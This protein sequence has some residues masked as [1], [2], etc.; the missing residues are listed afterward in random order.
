[1]KRKLSIILII[2]LLFT[3]LFSVPR[4]ANAATMYQKV[5]QYALNLGVIHIWGAVDKNGGIVW[6]YG[7]EKGGEKE[8][9]VTITMP[10][11]VSDVDAYQLTSSN[12]KW[13][14][15]N[16]DFNG[17]EYLYDKQSYD[18]FYKPYAS[19]N[20][21][22]IH[23]SSSGSKVSLSYTA[24]LKS[25]T[26]FDLAEAIRE[27]NVD[28]VYKLLGGAETLKKANYEL[29]QRLDEGTENGVGSGVYGYM[30]FVPIV[31]QYDVIEK[32]EIPEND[33]EPYLD[34]PEI[35]LTGETY[36]VIDQTEF[37][38]KDQF[39][40]S[41]LRYKAE[42]KESGD[43]IDSGDVEGWD[44]TKLGGSITQAFDEP[45]IVTYTITVWNIYGTSKS[46]AKTIKILAPQEEEPEITVDADLTL[47]EYTYEGHTE[48]ARDQS[49]YVVNGVA[50]SAKR[51]YAEDIASNRFKADDT[52]ID[53]D[54]LTDTKAECTFSKKGTYS[55]TLNVK[56]KTRVK[57]S[58]TESI[59][60]RKTPCI[61]DNLSGFQKQNRK[62]ILNAVVAT[63]PGKPI[64]DYTITL[65]DKVTGD[66]IRLTPDNLQ[67]N[68][69][70][71]KTRAVTMT[72][73]EEK[74]F[75]YL[76]LEFLTKTPAYN[77]A[78]PDYTQDF[79]YEIHVKDSKGDT[80][81]ASSTFPVKPDIP[82]TAAISLDSAFLR[83]EG[84]NTAAIKA[85]DVTVASD[86]D[87]VERTWYYAPSTT[88]S[89]FTNVT[90]MNGYQ[91]LSFGTDKIVGFNKTGVGKFTM[92]LHVKEVWTEPTLEEYVTDAEHLTDITTA[93]SDVQNVAPIVSLDLLRSTE[94]EILL[95]ANNNT[96]YQTLM[97][98]KTE[99]QQALLANCID[100]QI[101]IKKLVGSTPST[102]TKPSLQHSK[103]YPYGFHNPS[104]SNILAVDSEKTYLLTYAWTGVG[105]SSKH[106][107][108]KTIHAI[109]PYSGEAWSYTT[110]RE[111]HF[112]FGQDDTGKYLYLIYEDSNQTVFIDKRTGA[113]AGTINIALSN[114][115]WLSDNLAFITQ[116]HNIYAIN[117][118]SL[119]KTL[120]V[121]NAYAVSRV[122][123]N[124]QYIISTNNAIVRCTL[125][126]ETRSIEKNI[127]IESDSI[128]DYTPICIDSAG[129]AVL[130][131]EK[132]N[133]SDTFEGVVA[134]TADNNLSI[135]VSAG[136][137]YEDRSFI[138]HA[139]DEQGECNHVM[140]GSKDSYKK[141]DKCEFVGV[142]LKT[143]NTESY[144]KRTDNYGYMFGGA[145]GAFESNGTSYFLFSGDD[146]YYN[147]GTSHTWTGAYC[148][149]FTGSSCSLGFY[150]PG[151]GLMDE[152]IK[153][154]DRL[155]AS[156]DGEN[157]PEDGKLH[158]RILAFP[159]TLAQETKEVISRYTNKLTFVGDVNTTAS[160]IIA[161]TELPKSVMKITAANNGSLSLHN[162][163]L[164]QSK[165]YSYEYEIKPL[166][167]GTESKLNGMTA[168]TGT[169]TSSQNFISD[170][171]Y[172][173]DS[174][175]ENFN[176]EKI[177]NDFFTVEDNGAFSNGGYGSDEDIDSHMK[178]SFVVPDGKQAIVSFDYDF[179]F[180][181]GIYEDTNIFIDG[182]RVD[183]SP[184]AS[185]TYGDWELITTGHRMFYKILY[186]GV[187]TIETKKAYKGSWNHVL[188]DNLKVDILSTVPKTINPTINIEEGESEGW[189]H[190]SGT[191]KTLPKTISYGAQSSTYHSGNIASKVT[192]T[193]K[194]YS[195]GQQVTRPKEIEYYQTVP[196]GCYQR[197]FAYTSSDHYKSRR[198]T[199]IID[200]KRYELQHEDSDLTVF[201]PPKTAGTY[202]HSVKISKPKSDSAIISR[203]DLLTYPVNEVTATGNMAFNHSNTKYFFPKVTSNEKTNLSIYLPKGE[204]LIKNLRLYY[205]ENGQKIYMKN[206]DLDE[207]A[208]LSDWTLSTG[209][210]ASMMTVKE[211]KT[212][213]EYVKVYKKGE[214]VLYN[215]FYSD[216]EKDPSKIGYW[217]YTHINWPPDTVHP[218]VGKVL[219][220]PIDRFYLA[221]KYT[222]THWEVDNTQRPG[223][224]GDASS[225]DRESNKE[226]MTFYV[227]G[228][229][230]APWITY[231]KTNPSK[232]KE[233]NSY[234]LNVGVDD[235][236]KDTLTL[237]TEVYLNGKSV[238]TDIK[239]GIQADANGDY[240]E[241]TITGLPT[242]KIGVYQVVC[243]VSD[244]SGTGIKTYKF[245]VVSEGK[246]T[247]FVNHTDQ[248]DINRKKYNLKRFDDEVNRSMLLRDYL[249]LKT[250]RKRG[251]NVFWS[252]EKFMLQSETEGNPTKVTVR[253]LTEDSKGDNINTDYSTQLTNTGSKTALG[254]EIWKGNLWENS[255]INKWG[256]KTPEALNFQFVA[257][258][259]GGLTKTHTVSVI[260]DSERDYWQLHR[261]W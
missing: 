36:T 28:Y 175:E 160:E 87:E 92:K 124:L 229:G 34:V 1:M 173:V 219:T 210:T 49:T 51:A 81:T 157:D 197:G 121:E 203:F 191:F 59:E 100:G 120:V 258:Y 110:S 108:P 248:W 145:S 16:Y 11:E 79:Y 127:L 208:D 23:V 96:E 109:N 129:K 224:V 29:W 217:V 26:D 164:E 151:I 195:H 5:T 111:E 61:V 134:Y 249:A 41:Q 43:V 180:A 227:N 233:N 141:G 169:T 45:C 53:I 206:N 55:V 140:L 179:D 35:A 39:A 189:N 220:S 242:A 148:F 188:I 22:G 102:V 118:S 65:K 115:V 113:A 226:T 122:N 214:K 183:E 204:Y 190:I 154:S 78:V 14:E 131:K 86:G 132:G 68:H 237:E 38:K 167:D 143:G 207:V 18:H 168:T 63:Y 42:G 6:Q 138:N 12:F 247:G 163:E 25:N 90:S 181:A 74:G 82:P 176:S 252:G 95:L 64:T 150:G 149:T 17:T 193:E 251:T 130:F 200:G 60:V 185:P 47:P 238:K 156:I 62:Q 56:T 253:I 201:L 84:T 170:A 54:R 254:A 256:R 202:T 31:L 114:H 8:V 46:Y 44:G 136:I 133:G 66:L 240:P 97:N 142:D 117:L 19:T 187:H 137:R 58:D 158:F 178:M 199:Y 48:I 192:K 32:V 125:D 20:I 13:G 75:T 259:T 215:I 177:E 135:Q 24:S 40:E 116:N 205:I 172:V 80:D 221:G 222:V 146:D 212:D 70:T 223:T 101:I 30:F 246:I 196:A 235:T 255:M 174:Y 147:S 243:T 230:K 225:Y 9:S 50:Y 106:T 162:Q 112:T 119:T 198:V 67:E 123:G 57:A 89:T 186:P 88:P 239:T 103:T 184:T 76:T 77:S 165:K 104:E 4:E 234:T 27:D 245:T 71:I 257:N 250:P 171:L 85:E 209:L 99:L 182:L 260:I 91:K 72:Q 37:D 7:D 107:L 139:F 155:V 218:D 232:V 3:G 33:F 94:Q 98:K 10:E 261:L 21:S 93:N 73:D 216:Y 69:A 161:K 144:Y 152:N 194:Y 2:T 105:T 128:N 236:E 241:Q 231:I 213:D 83:N 15:E 52:S 126:M 153:T 244:Y 159:R 228:D 166:T 211:E